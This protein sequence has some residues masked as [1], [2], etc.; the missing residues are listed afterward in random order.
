MQVH[1][2]FSRF[3][4]S[5]GIE[6]LMLILRDSSDWIWTPWG[7]SFCL[8]IIIFPICIST[9]QPSRTRR[10]RATGCVVPGHSLGEVPLRDSYLLDYKPHPPLRNCPMSG[11]LVTAISKVM[12]TLMMHSDFL[13]TLLLFVA[14][15]WISIRAISEDQNNFCLRRCLKDFQ[16]QN[17]KTCGIQWFTLSFPVLL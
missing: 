15:V 17:I 4:I 13:L 11:I 3:C 1:F 16:Y 5:E 14:M 10:V 12:D 2:Q 9:Q 6:S 7:W 8:C